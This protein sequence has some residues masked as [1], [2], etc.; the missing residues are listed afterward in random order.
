MAYAVDWSFGFFFTL[1]NDGF[2]GGGM[3]RGLVFCHQGGGCCRLVVV[4]LVCLAVTSVIMLSIQPPTVLGV[5]RARYSRLDVDITATTRS[6]LVLWQRTT[7]AEPQ[8]DVFVL[9]GYE[10]NDFTSCSII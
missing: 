6:S 5:I 9:D 7:G 10:T 8:F 1:I 4:L 3:V 2:G